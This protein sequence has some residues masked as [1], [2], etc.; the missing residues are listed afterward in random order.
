MVAVPVVSLDQITY[1][2]E[3]SSGEVDGQLYEVLGEVILPPTLE[4]LSLLGF[5]MVSQDLVD[6]F[7]L[8]LGVLVLVPYDEKKRH[9]ALGK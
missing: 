2:I 8:L 4:F 1:F 5:L 6:K 9:F 7:R 3:E